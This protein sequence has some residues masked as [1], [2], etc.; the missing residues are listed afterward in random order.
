MEVF[1]EEFFGPVR[2][3]VRVRTL[4]EAIDLINKHQYGNGCCIFT[5]DGY[6]SRKFFESCE[7]G[8]IGVNVPVPIPPEF[9]NFGGFKRSRI[10]DGQMTG[11]DSFR[12]FTKMKTVSEK[13]FPST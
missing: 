12:F 7:V 5:N 2:I 4:D 3:I 13:W 1:K 6:A 8:M 9:F 10:G 11:P